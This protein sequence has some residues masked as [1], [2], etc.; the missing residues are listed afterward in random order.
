MLMVVPDADLYLGYMAA[1]M[2]RFAALDGCGS[3]ALVHGLIVG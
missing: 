1:S 3:Y 2:F